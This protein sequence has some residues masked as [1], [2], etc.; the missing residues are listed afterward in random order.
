[1]QNF[2]E[3]STKKMIVIGTRGN[4]VLNVLKIVNIYFEFKFFSLE[5]S[6]FCNITK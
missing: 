2:P 3:K 5:N 6:F 1:M 4:I